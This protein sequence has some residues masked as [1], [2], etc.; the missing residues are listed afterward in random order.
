[1]PTFSIPAAAAPGAAAGGTAA[2]G[3]IGATL[4]TIAPYA[5]LGGTLLSA[6]LGAAGAAQSAS[7]QQA[8]AN[9]QAQV[10]QNNQVIAE[11]NAR[12]A[13]QAGQVTAQGQD[14]QTRALVGRDIAGAA[15]SGLDVTTG[16]PSD[17]QTSRSELGRLSS[18]TDIQQG[19]LQAYGYQIGA[20]SEGAQAALDRAKAGFAGQAGG[21]G[22]ASSILGG[23]TSFASKWSN[24]QRTGAI[25]S[26][27]SGGA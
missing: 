23:A 18:L 8:S 17:V 5:S 22:V 2:A 25:G 9:Y 10:G 4:G 3:G 24:F 7:A 6:G 26:D 14:I 20:T 15:A 12:Y 1:M 21:I 27:F 16:S 13:T 11:Q 19:N